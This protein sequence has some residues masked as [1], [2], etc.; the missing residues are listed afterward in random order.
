MIR[1]TINDACG[2]LGITR[3][4]LHERIKKAG[5]KPVKEGRYSYL[6]EEQLQEVATNVSKA[7]Y[8]EYVGKSN[9]SGK[10]F[11][12]SG[13]TLKDD[14]IAFLKDQLEKSEARE[15]HL[16]S[17]LDKADA[18]E[19]QLMTQIEKHMEAETRLQTMVMHFEKRTQ[20]LSQKLLE[21]PR[22]IDAEAEEITTGI[23]ERVLDAV[24]W[25]DLKKARKRK[26]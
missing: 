6:T 8:R 15:S 1:Y 21:A 26:K 20:E 5:L 12:M 4:T 2:K 13:D 14:L 16:K 25:K 24:K 9:V 10:N 3:Q 11:H 17:Q 19:S 18:K 23:I 7:T 22:P